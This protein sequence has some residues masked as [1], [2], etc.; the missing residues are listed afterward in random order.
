MQT[1]KKFGLSNGQISMQVE[2]VDTNEKGRD[3]EGEPVT[4]NVKK[5]CQV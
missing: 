4:Q 5:L 1:C 3:Q 2:V